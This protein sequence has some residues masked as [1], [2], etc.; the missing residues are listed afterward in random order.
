[1]LAVMTAERMAEVGSWNRCASPKVVTGWTTSEQAQQMALEGNPS[2]KAV[3]A[4]VRQAAERVRQ[5]RSAYFPQVDA[6][7]SATHTDLS[8]LS[9]ENAR[10]TAL[11]RKHVVAPRLPL[12]FCSLYSVSAPSA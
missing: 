3:E 7:W 5:A 1:M 12:N 11:T 6:S 10:R 4:R 8:D 9:V 2:L